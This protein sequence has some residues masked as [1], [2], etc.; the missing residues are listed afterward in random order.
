MILAIVRGYVRSRVRAVLAVL[1]L[2][3]AALTFLMGYGAYRETILENDAVRLDRMIAEFPPEAQRA[4][5]QMVSRSQSDY[6]AQLSLVRFYHEFYGKQSGSRLVYDLLHGQVEPQARVCGLLSRSGSSLSDEFYQDFARLMATAEGLKGPQYDA[7]CRLLEMQTNVLQAARE[8]GGQTWDIV[9]RD[10]VSAAVYAACHL[11]EKGSE[12]WPIYCRH[13]WMPWAVSLLSVLEVRDAGMSV[14]GGDGALAVCDRILE[15]VGLCG[16]YEPMQRFLAGVYKRARQEETEHA[17]GEDG[18]ADQQVEYLMNLALAYDGFKYFGA[19]LEA[20]CGRGVEVAMALDM[21]ALNSVLLE[22]CKTQGKTGQFYDG[23]AQLSQNRELALVGQGYPGFLNLYLMDSLSVEKAGV[24]CWGAGASNMLFAACSEV[25]GQLNSEALRQALRALGQYRQLAMAVYASEK[26]GG[27]A[28]FAGIVAK[29]WRTVPYLAKHMEEGLRKL[30]PLDR[31]TLVKVL[32]D[33]L[34]AEGW[35]RSDGWWEYLP[36]VGASAK[37]FR[38][39]VT[40]RPIEFSD[41]G[42]AAWE[43]MD[44]ACLVVSMGGSAAVLGSI[45]AASAGAKVAAVGFRAGKNA[46]YG[47]VR[48]VGDEV[49]HKGIGAAHRTAFSGVGKTS[50]LVM[51]IT[52]MSKAAALS[53]AGKPLIGQALR[54]VKGTY[55]V[56]TA[57]L[58]KVGNTLLASPGLSRVVCVVMLSLEVYGRTYPHLPEI[59]QGLSDILWKAARMAAENVPELMERWTEALRQSV[60]PEKKEIPEWAMLHRRTWLCWLATLV[61]LFLGFRMGWLAL[62]GS[63]PRKT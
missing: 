37:L 22:D 47:A 52:R 31:E 6:A 36:L 19:E 3:A 39:L 48:K 54:L 50:N 18:A 38:D 7:L 43:V 35:P 8:E 23:V 16:Q 46:V 32:D 55:R 49:T 42:W 30:A 13:E 12:L 58:R 2:I 10:P 45:K 9:K 51:R 56:S 5:E 34:T 63:S 29:D 60:L 53:V 26:L 11:S 62:F 14:D 40:G 4:Y 25:D 33:E 15:F 28:R 21:V 61:A 1:L 44:A 20:L 41:V 59:V 27:D 57:V 24:V 17:A